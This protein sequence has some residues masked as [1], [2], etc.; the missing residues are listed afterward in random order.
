MRVAADS[1]A[2]AGVVRFP[3]LF[4]FYASMRGSD[5][6]IQ[7]GTYMLHRDA[8]WGFAL[9][10]LRA[11]KGIVHTEEITLER[12]RRRPLWEKIVGPF[13]WILERQQ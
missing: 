2:R 1:L 6:Q 4:R 7:S 12:W 10:A 9:N 5:R 11:G 3:R 13:V 8:G